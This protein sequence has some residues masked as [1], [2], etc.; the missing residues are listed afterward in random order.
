MKSFSTTLN[1]RVLENISVSKLI[2][3][4]SET[5]EIKT[6]I[7]RSWEK[8]LYAMTGKANQ[9]NFVGCSAEHSSAGWPS[10]SV[11]FATNLVGSPAVCQKAFVK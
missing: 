10:A 1:T 2:K 9:T 4:F 6:S 8:Y 11:R 7:R 5:N 3:F